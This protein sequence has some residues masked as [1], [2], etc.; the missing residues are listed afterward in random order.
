MWPF[1][2]KYPD[3][4][5]ECGSELVIRTNPSMQSPGSFDVWL[6]CP[7][8]SIWTPHYQ[9]YIRNEKS[10]PKYDTKTGERL[11]CKHGDQGC[12]C[13]KVQSG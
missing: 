6:V 13:G 7:R 3:Y 5:Q 12:I 10:A 11:G 9:E 4:C 1:K 2:K 8:Y